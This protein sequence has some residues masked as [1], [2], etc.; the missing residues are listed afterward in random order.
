MA[1]QCELYPE[2]NY[3]LFDLAAPFDIEPEVGDLKAVQ[4]VNLDPFPDLIQKFRVQQ[5]QAAHLAAQLISQHLGQ[6]N[7]QHH[8]GSTISKLRKKV[9]SIAELELQKSV[10]QLQNGA[11]A[12]Q[13]MA[14]FSRKLANKIL[15]EP[16]VSKHQN[17]DQDTAELIHFVE[18]LFQL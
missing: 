4:L 14:E 6:F 17:Q 8:I 12:D 13:V 18:K 16:T 2:Q 9:H 10:L 15:H 11:A 1:Q 7:H 3:I 5:T